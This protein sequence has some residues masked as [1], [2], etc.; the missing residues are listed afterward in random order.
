MPEVTSPVGNLHRSDPGVGCVSLC[1]YALAEV[2]WRQR[3]A[4]GRSQKVYR[5]RAKKL[6]R[7]RAGDTPFS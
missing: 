7:S 4:L 6:S 1:M 5:M 2:S 3:A